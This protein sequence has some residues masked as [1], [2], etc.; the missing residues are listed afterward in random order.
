MLEQFFR[1][2]GC[3]AVTAF[4]P[5]AYIVAQQVYQWQAIPILVGEKLPLAGPG[6]I[7]LVP[8][9]SR[10]ALSA[11]TG[12][13]RFPVVIPIVVRLLIRIAEDGPLDWLDW[14]MLGHNS[15]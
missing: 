2:I 10:P 1:D 8:I 3:S 9:T 4:P 7:G 14:R 13:T 6:A 15:T 5:A 12:S 11:V